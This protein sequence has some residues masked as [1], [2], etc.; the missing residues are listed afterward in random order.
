MRTLDCAHKL[1]IRYLLP[2][3]VEASFLDR[4]PDCEVE[5]QR[6]SQFVVGAKDQFTVRCE[7]LWRVAGVIGNNELTATFGKPHGA[8][9]AEELV[10]AFEATLGEVFGPVET[11]VRD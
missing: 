9:E 4:F 8:A 3:P 11:V 7:Q 2:T 10:A 6:F 1:R 5:L